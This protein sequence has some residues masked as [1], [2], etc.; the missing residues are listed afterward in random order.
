MYLNVLIVKAAAKDYKYIFLLF[1]SSFMYF[2]TYTPTRIKGAWIDIQK[3]YILT[4]YTLF[5][6]SFLMQYGI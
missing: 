5:I 3:A 2:H 6:S 1:N 4:N